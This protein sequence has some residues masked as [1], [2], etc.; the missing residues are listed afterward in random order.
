MS[1]PAVPNRS[2]LDH[3][4]KLKEMVGTEQISN[5]KEGRGGRRRGGE[6]GRNK[7]R[8]QKARPSVITI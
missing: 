8:G 6:K 3:D 2:G 5:W 7:G 4:Q 1:I